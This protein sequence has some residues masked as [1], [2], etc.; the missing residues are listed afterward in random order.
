MSKLEK[1]ILVLQKRVAALENQLKQ[2]ANLSEIREMLA[3][4]T[5]S[6]RSSGKSTGLE[7]TDMGYYDSKR[8]QSHILQTR[9]RSL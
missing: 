6:M 5:K 2:D 1:Q 3:D 8:P 7:A 9:F 4:I